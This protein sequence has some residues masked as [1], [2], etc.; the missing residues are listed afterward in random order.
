M[1]SDRKYRS[2]FS[3]PQPRSPLRECCVSIQGLD[4][5]S[6]QVEIKAGT[7]DA[8]PRSHVVAGFLGRLG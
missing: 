4:G 2:P 6:L 7:C 5:E 1:G 3:Y 8:G